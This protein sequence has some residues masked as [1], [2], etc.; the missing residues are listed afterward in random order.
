MSELGV[1]DINWGNAE[2]TANN[3]VGALDAFLMPIIGNG[4][5]LAAIN[6][7]VGS[8]VFILTFLV[9]LVMQSVIAIGSWF[10]AAFLEML[11]TAQED[12][13]DQLNALLAA[14]ANE[15]LGTSLS[16]DALGSDGQAGGGMADNEA[17]GDALLS[18][19][20]QAF[21]ATGPLTAEQ[22]ASNARKF[23]GYNV[24]FATTQGFLSI[25]AEAVS[26]GFLKEFHELPDALRASLGLG[27]LSR[28]ALQPLIQNAIQLPYHRY[29]LAKYRPT[30]LAEAQLVKALHSG[31]MQEGDVR[32]ALAELGY[33][34]DLIDFVIRDV[35]EKLALSEQMTLLEN[36]LIQEADVINNL[37]LLGLPEDQAKLQLTASKLATAKGDVDSLLTEVGA[38]YVAG[39][40]DLGT[41]NKFVDAAPIADE[42]A[43]AFRALI[44]FRKEG[45][46]KTVSFADVK[47]AVV[48]AVVTFDYVDTWL[49]NAGYGPD[50]QN[51]LFFQVL[52]AMKKEADKESYKKYKAAQLTAKGKPVPPWLMPGSS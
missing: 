5:L 7:V 39:L 38:S 52:E 42:K 2:T 21:D 24:K 10:G 20:E 12:N 45:P 3:V 28:L 46:R 19:F 31:D 23:A 30:K 17:I 37:T 51:I 15:A 13:R 34:D 50:D 43:E 1:P 11:G 14:S 18:I 44:G 29:T 22:G 16:A 27:R 9:L 47:D 49:A 8:F 40:I 35:A 32:A 4:F 25:M 41:F 6:G 26:L 33:S 36:G 48:N